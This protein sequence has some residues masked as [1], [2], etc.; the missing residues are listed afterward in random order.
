MKLK[1]FVLVLILG[2]SF[3]VISAHDNN[4]AD[5]GDAVDPDLDYVD[6]D[7]EEL[8]ARAIWAIQQRKAILDTLKS[9]LDALERNA[10]SVAQDER[11]FRAIT[12]DLDVMFPGEGEVWERLDRVIKK[13]KALEKEEKRKEK[14]AYVVSKSFL[15]SLVTSLV[16]GSC[17]GAY[18][19]NNY[20]NG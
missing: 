1:S 6:V 11:L 13:V 5:N 15:V 12:N 20:L 19:R 8:K 2:C 4:A 3:C 10:D 18:F 17:F 7:F 9:K 16:V 14:K